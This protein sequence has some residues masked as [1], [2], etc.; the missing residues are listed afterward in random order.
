MRPQTQNNVCSYFLPSCLRFPSSG[1]ATL[2]YTTTNGKTIRRTGLLL[3]KKTAAYMSRSHRKNGGKTYGCCFRPAFRINSAAAAR[4]AKASS[5]PRGV[6]SPVW[7][8]EATV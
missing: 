1:S 3:E 4:P 2:S 6:V 8:T 5:I 7:G